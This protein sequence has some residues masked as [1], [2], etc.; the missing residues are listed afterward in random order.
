MYRVPLQCGVIAAISVAAVSGALAAPSTTTAAAD[1]PWDGFDEVRIAIVAGLVQPVLLGGGNVEVDVYYRRW[2]FGY[3]HGFLLNLEG[4]AVVGDAND[5]GLAFEVPF[6]T[7]ASAGFR[8]LEWLDA[9]VEGKVHR[10]EVRDEASSQDLFDYTTV[11]LGVGVYAQYRPFYHFGVDAA[12]WLQGW[13]IVS[14][15]R[16]WPRIWSSLDDDEI[17]YDSPTTGQTERHEAAQIGIANTPFIFNI[18][19]GYLVRF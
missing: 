19:V 3:S 15:V 12:E 2:V 6:T 11:T 10:F 4:D 14:S 13:L 5:Q 1:E 8:F 16:F 7:G 9:R 17:V 18:S